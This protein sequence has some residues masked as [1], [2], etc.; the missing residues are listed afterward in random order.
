M[1][2][3]HILP[4]TL[5]DYVLS[6]VQVIDGRLPMAQQQG[7]KEIS[8][9]RVLKYLDDSLWELDAWP[10]WLIV[11]FTLLLVLIPGVRWAVFGLAVGIVLGVLMKPLLV[12]WQEEE[13]VP[14][15]PV[16]LDYATTQTLVRS[17]VSLSSVVSS[18]K[19]LSQ[20][21]KLGHVVIQ[22]FVTR[23][24]FGPHIQQKFHDAQCLEFAPLLESVL[25]YALAR[26]VQQAMRPA[27]Q[28][29]ITRI[30]DRIVTVLL[31]HLREFINFTQA[32]M[33]L[34]DYLRKVSMDGIWTRLST[35]GKQQQFLR[36]LSQRI[37]RVC[38]PPDV[39]SS[40]PAIP[41]LIRELLAVFVLDQIVQPTSDPDL[42]NRLIVKGMEDLSKHKAQWEIEE[43]NGVP[44]AAP[45]AN[46][47]VTVRPDGEDVE[48]TDVF[49]RLVE[50]RHFFIAQRNPDSD[51]QAIVSILKV[52]SRS[53]TGDE[54]QVLLTAKSHKVE[55]DSEPLWGTE[56]KF[57][58]PVTNFDDLVLRIAFSIPAPSGYLP[59]LFADS[60]ARAIVG[61]IDF[62]LSGLEANKL[63]RQWFPVD[64]VVDSTV[65]IGGI[66]GG[67]VLFE[68]FR[69]ATEME[70]EE[71][72]RKSGNVRSSLELNRATPQPTASPV[73]PAT[74]QP[75]PP[76]QPVPSPVA[77]A[78]I[79]QRSASLHF[80]STSSLP[81][82]M[83][84]PSP[85]ASIAPSEP[86]LTPQKHHT[87]EK[88]PEK[89]LPPIF[90]PL[91][92][93]P[94]GPIQ[95]SVDDVSQ[96][97]EVPR[98]NSSLSRMEET[99]SPSPRARSRSPSKSMEPIADFFRKLTPK[100]HGP[101]K[102][103]EVPSFETSSVHT[104]V[105]DLDHATLAR[106]LQGNPSGTSTVFGTGMPPAKDLLYTI[107]VKRHHSF[108]DAGRILVRSLADFRI[109]HELLS[110]K[111]DKVA[112]TPLPT[113]PTS[114]ALEKRRLLLESNLD[115]WLRVLCTDGQAMHLEA[116]VK[117]LA[118]DVID[119]PSSVSYSSAG[120]GEVLGGAMLTA[121]TGLGK[122]V[123]SLGGAV[124]DV[125]G[126]VGKGIVTGFESIGSSVANLGTTPSPS[127][128]RSSVDYSRSSMDVALRTDM[129]PD[130]KAKSAMKDTITSVNSVSSVGSIG[131]NGKEHVEVDAVVLD[132]PD[133]QPRRMLASTWRLIDRVFQ[134]DTFPLIRAQSLRLIKNVV[135]HSYM[136]KITRSIDGALAKVVTQDAVAGYIQPLFDRF[137]P[138]GIW[139]KQDAT[140]TE[141]R[142]RTM[143]E[144]EATKL[145]A[146]NY[147]TSTSGD[148]IN[149]LLQLDKLVGR[150]S[151]VGGL[152][153]MFNLLQN[154]E[155]NKIL[156]CELLEVLVEELI[157]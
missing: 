113:K 19:L 101:R 58:L 107:E 123:G 126:G 16:K 150:Q 34:Q 8:V 68:L 139:H 3:F 120:V 9:R 5:V 50:G 36:E 99:P 74:P 115:S 44:N 97:S 117:F 142:P 122:G 55:L 23:L 129:K 78:G 130:S 146:K 96:H 25:D 127:P 118:A 56:F 106:T 109:L 82:P 72:L 41:I 79:A 76:P 20:L 114:G 147:L 2:T 104:K 54:E 33:P 156:L 90:K 10:R 116:L 59:S 57:L 28:I 24:W 15:V 18:P 29:S 94:S 145:Q 103:E 60:D 26:I 63:Y 155:L 137:W 46:Q 93:T 35:R 65:G 80:T 148:G 138:N 14:K 86:I 135:R 43:L 92:I 51:L 100:P 75:Q 136:D 1:E 131:K 53:N 91:P 42:M 17:N 87:P 7:N 73:P 128:L 27:P 6:A 140:F 141:P 98:R 4:Q 105:V 85:S 83:R 64:D 69:I 71:M 11:G 45:A 39:E 30:Y 49:V 108:E 124:V 149:L 38:L 61:K 32:G 40:S 12:E 111:L 154:Q 157:E 13:V 95:F 37:C 144:K 88:S 134:A 121:V 133:V 125:V 151:R 47:V 77:D 153:R 22:D 48:T 52:L 70:M 81:E 143:Q 132:W 21:S 112:H 31:R 152:G 66:G 62:P 119:Y 102:S 110:G 84:S 89:E 67:E